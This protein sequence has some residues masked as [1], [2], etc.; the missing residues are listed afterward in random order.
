VIA[1]ALF[2]ALGTA[3]AAADPPCPNEAIRE[4]QHSTYLPECRAFELVSPAR[5]NGNQVGG[6]DPNALGA[7]L[8]VSADGS[9]ITNPGAYPLP[10]A[11]TGSLSGL[12]G[13]RTSAGWS[14]QGIAAAPGP[15]QPG[16]G[17]SGQDTQFRGATPDQQTAVYWNTTTVPWGS[18]WL[19][20]ADGSQI[21]IADATAFGPSNGGGVFP[22]QPWFQTISDNGQHVVFA[23]DS[24]LLPGLPEGFNTILYDWFDDGSPGGLLRVVNRTNAGTLTLIDETA[25]ASLGGSVPTIEDRAIPGIKGLRNA[26]SADGSRIY[27]QTPA[28]E[29]VEPANDPRPLRGGPVYLREDGA[30]T[31]EVSAPAPGYTPVNPAASYQYLDASHSL[32][33]PA[34]D[35]RFVYFWANG[36]LTPGAPAQGGIYRYDAVAERLEFRAEASYGGTDAPTGMASP[37]GSLLYFQ[38]PATSEDPPA[39]MVSTDAGEKAVA[40][41]VEVGSGGDIALELG[42]TDE[43]CVSANLSSS[44]RFFTFATNAGDIDRFDAANGTLELIAHVTPRL[45]SYWEANAACVYY[46]PRVS[47]RI[48]SDDGQL[49]YFDTTESLVPRDTNGVSDVYLWRASDR[50]RR[51]VSSGTAPGGAMLGGASADGSSIFIYT[52]QQLVP[53]DVDKVNDLYVAR[54]DGGFASPSEVECEAEACQGELGVPPARAAVR[55]ELE[56]EP[57]RRS[58]RSGARNA[59]P[60]VSAPRRTVGIVASLAVT[61]AEPGTLRVSGRGLAAIRVKAGKGTRRIRARLAQGAAKQLRR[62]GRYSTVATVTFIARSGG[63]SVA[64]ARLNYKTTKASGRGA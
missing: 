43:L 26:V 33:D 41:A 29:P 9:R 51:L 45:S 63:K 50:S 4:E 13:I 7:E 42:I 52:A 25:S 16:L 20:R 48:A 46:A 11:P 14:N 28:S 5:K 44:G 53:Q 58:R 17:I 22:G 64:K 38:R 10:P 36:D 57:R 15:V 32:A 59:R 40:S 1:T 23:T 39:V 12:F 30:V 56:V 60:R 54:I 47:G 34:V 55:S 24:R 61:V 27:F 62:V 18:L 19:S 31:T 6:N 37:D 2:A 8:G 21:K 35:G 49:V 3:H